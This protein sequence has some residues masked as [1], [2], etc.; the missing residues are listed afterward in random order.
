MEPRAENERSQ[1]RTPIPDRLKGLSARLARF[2]PPH[3]DELTTP[4]NF[5]V[6]ALYALVKAHAL[7]YDGN[8]QVGRGR[9]MWQSASRIAENLALVGEL[10]TAEE[11]LAGYYFND[12]IIRIAVS[13]EHIVRYVTK[14]REGGN[15]QTLITAATLLGFSK[16]WGAAW[17]PMQRE[18]NAIRHRNDFIEGPQSDVSLS[19]AVDALEQLIDT[20]TW[21]LQYDAGSDHANPA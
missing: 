14:E 21:G 1:Q 19:F 18:L 20:L 4:L 3:N 2:A 15:I 7:K 12:G 16:K 11:W 10:P 9:R 8:T 6:G 5:A 17:K 13:F